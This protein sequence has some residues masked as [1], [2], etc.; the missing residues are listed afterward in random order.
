MPR[1][2]RSGKTIFGVELTAAERKAWEKEMTKTLA[3]WDSKH[4]RELAATILWY[5]HEVEGYG[6]K[7][8]RRVHRGFNEAIDG[9]LA[10]YELDGE[11]DIWLC[12]T[13]LKEAGFDIEAWDR[14]LEKERG[15]K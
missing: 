11:D 4:A 1:F 2:K 8:L 9:L 13:K 7:R 10:R 12:T 6:E 5:L 15:G 3:E 14:E